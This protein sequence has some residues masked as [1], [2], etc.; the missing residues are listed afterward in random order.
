MRIIRKPSPAQALR[1]ANQRA[2]L[3][4]LRRAVAADLAR[5]I[6]AL[7]IKRKE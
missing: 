6:A 5:L 4:A 1:E 2:G 7:P 3:E